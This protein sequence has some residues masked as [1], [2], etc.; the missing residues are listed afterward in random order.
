MKEP[1]TQS[2]LRWAESVAQ[3][4]QTIHTVIRRKLLAGGDVEPGARA[5]KPDA[6]M[7]PVPVAAVLVSQ[8]EED[9]NPVALVRALLDG[10]DV[11]ALSGAGFRVAART[12][13]RANVRV[14]GELLN[15]LEGEVA[16]CSAEYLASLRSAG[17][18]G[19]LESFARESAR[20]RRSLR[21]L[22]AAGWLYRLR[23]PQAAGVG[24]RA[25]DALGRA[26]TAMLELCKAIDPRPSVPI[27]EA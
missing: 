3:L 7:T 13:R 20:M 26:Q 16:R 21:A 22:K 18:Y 14:Y 1:V 5:L 27:P 19:L 17:D 2:D 8:D 25:L 24:N 10:T 9:L 15:V 23:V 4:L 12:R 11:R 6:I